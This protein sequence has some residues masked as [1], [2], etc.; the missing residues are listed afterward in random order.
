MIGGHEEVNPAYF[1]LSQ[2]RVGDIVAGNNYSFGNWF[3]K[4]L[5]DDRR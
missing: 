2:K 5:N 1:F 4:G 3:T